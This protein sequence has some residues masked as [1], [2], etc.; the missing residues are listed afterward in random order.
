MPFRCFAAFIAIVA[1]SRAMADSSTLSFDPPKLCEWQQANNNMNTAEC[2]KL[3]EESK[4]AM[5][6]LEAAAD[7]AR[8]DECL[9][10]AKNFSGDS[11]YASYTVY[12]ECLKN[13]PGNL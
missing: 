12:A 3:E 10:E 8:K 6:D 5:A 9:E 7:Q 11:G 2:L 1:A 4:A 13:G